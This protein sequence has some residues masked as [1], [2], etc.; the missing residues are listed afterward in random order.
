MMGMFEALLLVSLD[1]F[2]DCGIVILRGVTN[3]TK[4]LFGSW[5]SPLKVNEN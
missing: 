5:T 2:I 1:F 3:F 4:I